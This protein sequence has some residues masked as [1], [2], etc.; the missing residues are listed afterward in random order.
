MSITT[1]TPFEHIL[2]YLLIPKSGSKTVYLWD[3][4]LF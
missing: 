3:F 4:R 1:I 2:L